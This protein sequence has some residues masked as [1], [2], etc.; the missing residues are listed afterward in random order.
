MDNGKPAAGGGRREGRRRPPS[1]A[2]VALTHPLHV[3]CVVGPSLTEVGNELKVTLG[4]AAAFWLMGPGR[5]GGCLTIRSGERERRCSPGS[6][7][8]GGGQGAVSMLQERSWWAPKLATAP[9]PLFSPQASGFPANRAPPRSPCPNF[10]SFIGHL[11][12]W[13]LSP[14]SPRTPKHQPSLSRRIRICSSQTCMARR[15]NWYFYL[16]PPFPASRGHP[17]PSPQG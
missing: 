3:P 9:V 6:G 12:L 8:G 2:V 16:Q 5:A 17:P 10:S 7:L 13:A 1:L 14:L 15:C 11:K 4:T